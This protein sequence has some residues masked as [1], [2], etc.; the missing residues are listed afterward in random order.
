MG[1]IEIPQNIRINGHRLHMT[2]HEKEIIPKLLRINN[3]PIEIS[4]IPQNK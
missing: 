3:N 2:C 4:I 1:S